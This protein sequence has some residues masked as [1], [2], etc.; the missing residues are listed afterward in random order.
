[1]KLEFGSEPG[2]IDIL[3]M[4]SSEN[5]RVSL[6]KNLKARGCPEADRWIHLPQ[7]KKWI[8]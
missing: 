3:A 4:F 2:S 7:R 8:T 6:G 1:M 5:E